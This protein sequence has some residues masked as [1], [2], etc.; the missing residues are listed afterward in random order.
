MGTVI[1]FQPWRVSELYPHIGKIMTQWGFLDFP[2]RAA[3]AAVHGLPAAKRIEQEP[4][5]AMSRRL[6]FLRKTT[7]KI[8]ELA[9]FTER[10]ADLC[11][12]VAK[13]GEIRDGLAHGY[14]SFYEIESGT[15]AFMRLDSGD[16]THTS[17]ELRITIPELI[18][19]G[20]AIEW[21]ANDFGVLAHDILDSGVV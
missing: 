16:T 21:L 7:R 9:S 2:V 13:F 4:P 3:V 6:R 12:R 5:R 14:P 20:S 8:P 1:E 11:G 15:I 10:T 19:A 18:G 17:Q